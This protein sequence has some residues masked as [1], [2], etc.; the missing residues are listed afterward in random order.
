MSSKPATTYQIVKFKLAF[1]SLRDWHH[2]AHWKLGVVSPI[3][4]LFVTDDA[5][6]AL[7]RD[8]QEFI[9]PNFVT[10]ATFV[11]PM[12]IT[13]SVKTTKDERRRYLGGLFE[14]AGIDSHRGRLPMNWVKLRDQQEEFGNVVD[15][16][17]LGLLPQRP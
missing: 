12:S 5:M 4:C 16:K 8:R 15:K 11:R 2:M 1:L 7:R 17:Y 14:R 10:T 6:S 9:A 3:F 13:E